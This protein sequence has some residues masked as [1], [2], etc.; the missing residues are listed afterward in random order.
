[1]FAA[2]KT[3]QGK[4]P[5]VAISLTLPVM[6]WGLTNEGQAVVKRA[7][8]TGLKFQVNIMA[9]DYGGSQYAGAAG[10]QGN[11]AIAAGTALATFLKTV[12]TDK[13][14]AQVYNSIWICPMIG[15]NDVADETFTLAD[16]VKLR[17]WGV[18]KG[19]AGLT[20]WSVNRYELSV[21]MKGI[22][23]GAGE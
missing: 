18:T 11:N 3:I 16:A 2:L 9:M 20:F 23:M 14:E 13:T 1:M 4:N 22:G 15:V 19:V 12:W 17:N 6:P 10:Q 8:A 7:A 5:N 21:R